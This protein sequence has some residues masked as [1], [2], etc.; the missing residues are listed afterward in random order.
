M[1]EW[2]MFWHPCSGLAGGC[3]AGGLTWVVA[4]AIEWC[5]R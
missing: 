3:I 2:W 1:I 5:F 4:A